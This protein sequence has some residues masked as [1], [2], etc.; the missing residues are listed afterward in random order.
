MNGKEFKLE[1]R[2]KTADHPLIRK[3]FQQCKHAP[4]KFQVDYDISQ[5]MKNKEK[6]DP[7]HVASLLIISLFT[8]FL[9]SNSASTITW[10]LINIACNVYELKKFNWSAVVLCFLEEGLKKHDKEKPVTLSG[11]LILILYWF[12]ENTKAKRCIQGREADSPTFTRWLIQKIFD[13]ET[14]KHIPN[15]AEKGPWNKTEETAKTINLD[16][17]CIDLDDDEKETPSFSEWVSQATRETKE[18]AEQAATNLKE[19]IN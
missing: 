11:C 19:V 7:E 1:K 16:T 10:D 15:I 5:E 13:L 12:L 3:R 18:E 6:R 17:D 14:F 2:Q 9:F 8:S 4:T